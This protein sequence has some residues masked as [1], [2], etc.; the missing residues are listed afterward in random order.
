MNSEIKI[1]NNSQFGEIRTAKTE[2]G[3]PLFCLVDLCSALKL[4]NNRKVKSQLDDDVTLSYPIIDSLGRNQDATFV[5][6]SGMYTVIL[7]SDSPLAKPMQK[8]VTSEVLPAIRKTGG[9]IAA[10]PE[11]TAEEIMARALLVANDTINRIKTNLEAKERQVQIQAHTLKEQ[12]PKVEYHDEV[13]NSEGLINTTVIAKDLGMSAG[14]LNKKLNQA[15]IIY[16]S[17][18]TWVPYS[19]YQDKGFCKSKTFP[20]VDSNGKQK[21]AIHFYW[22]EKGREFIMGKFLNYANA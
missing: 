4:T 15:G 1:F 11:E 18:E 12:A 9:Y 8:W 5:T 6:E 16:R 3:E 22:T 7:R 13:L 17:G 2:N 20:Y 21:T 19:K 10:K 14:A